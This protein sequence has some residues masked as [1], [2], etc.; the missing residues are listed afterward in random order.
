MSDPDSKEVF[1]PGVQDGFKKRFPND[2][3]KI[4]E[5]SDFGVDTSDIVLL[6]QIARGAYGIVYKGV[7]KGKTYAIKVQEAV[8]ALEEQIN[9]LVE[10][11]LLKSLHHERLVSSYGSSRIVEKRSPFEV[12]VSIFFQAFLFIN[13][14]IDNDCDGTL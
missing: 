3:F 9:I 1:L 13:A 12:K 14:K 11:T 10:L 6:D 4:S 7:V 5:E 8:P 2:D